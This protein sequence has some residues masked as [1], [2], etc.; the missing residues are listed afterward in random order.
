VSKKGSRKTTIN[1]YESLRVAAAN[2]S[3]AARLITYQPLLTSPQLTL[4]EDR[5]RFYPDD[6]RPPA[7]IY[8]SATQP[9]AR[10]SY[11]K[12]PG[13]KYSFRP[14]QTKA[15]IAFKA[16]EAVAVCVR[17]KVRKEIM[18]AMGKAG[19]KVRKPKHNSLS[20]YRC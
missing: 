6:F 2:T 15:V 14:K 12:R 18:H 3:H 17:R 19:G 8:K 7:A 9:V 11:S 13:V 1:S 4:L 5:R 10:L 20:K 16:P